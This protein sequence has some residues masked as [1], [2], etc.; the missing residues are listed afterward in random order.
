LS[1]NE[2]THEI[3]TAA[4]G[5]DGGGGGSTVVVSPGDERDEF[6][7]PHVQQIEP[8]GEGSQAE[9]L[10]SGQQPGDDEPHESQEPDEE[11]APR[12]E[13]EPHEEAPREAIAE[14][15]QP[16]DERDLVL[17]DRG[18]LDKVL[19]QEKKRLDNF[20]APAKPPGGYGDPY[21]MGLLGRLREPERRPNEPILMVGPGTRDA[22]AFDPALLD[23]KPG[24]AELRREAS[25][26]V[27]TGETIQSDPAHANDTPSP[28]PGPDA[29]QFDA[30]E[31]EGNQGAQNEDA[32]LTV[33]SFRLALFYLD[34]PAAVIEQAVALVGPFLPGNDPGPILSSEA[35]VVDGA[36]LLE[37]LP[38][39]SSVYSTLMAA[40]RI[41]ADRL[42]A[43]LTE[44]GTVTGLETAE[45]SQMIQATMLVGLQERGL[46]AERV[47]RG[48]TATG[49][50]SEAALRAMLVA[51]KVPI[52]EQDA[53]V[54]L[55]SVYARQGLDPLGGDDFGSHRK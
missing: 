42:A 40:I 36:P 10:T 23:Q 48:T 9:G 30:A 18:P 11:S 22:G 8:H 2:P 49:A 51:W 46:T 32:G 45:F 19:D 38:A 41:Q 17:E 14:E 37:E 7:E 29:E 28:E 20:M 34:V 24:D 3:E 47:N 35:A 44:A 21:G 1:S 27:T 39:D 31:S 52:N 12:A 5:G 13:I 4:S 15:S 53:I 50:P 54:N 26:E 6:K 55:C 43:R 25:E 33:T 16:R